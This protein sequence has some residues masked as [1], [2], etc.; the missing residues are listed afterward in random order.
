MKTG[1]YDF[2]IVPF[3]ISPKDGIFKEDEEPLKFRKDKMP[4]LKPAF[5]KTGTI[6]AAN[7]SKLNDGACSLILMSEERVKKTG[8]KPLAR[9]VSYADA[10]VDPIDF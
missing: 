8:V 5:S 10:E 6:T 7:A 4:L 1:K 3:E 9:L 2:E